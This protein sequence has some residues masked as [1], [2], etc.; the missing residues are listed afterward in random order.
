MS[1]KP[2]K[3]VVMHG[4]SQDEA[5]AAMRAIKASLQVQNEV[6]FAMSTETNLEWKLSD[7][8]EHVLEEHKFMTRTT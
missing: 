3:V 8:V 2:G 4:L 1:Q 7:L 6:A 5:V